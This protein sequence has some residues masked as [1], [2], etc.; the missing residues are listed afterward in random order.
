MK[1]NGITFF[2]IFILTVFA[3]AIFYFFHTICA[4]Y[5]NGLS[6]SEQIFRK[7]SALAENSPDKIKTELFSNE[8]GI[9]SAKYSKNNKTLIAYPDEQTASQVINSKLVKVFYKTI[10]IQE[11]T[12]ELKIASYILRPITRPE[13]VLSRYWQRRLQLS[14]Y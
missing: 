4:D 7:V 2:S 13:T 10:V 8:A 9:L 3:A 14:P 11:D 1:R 5:K 6:R 12:Y